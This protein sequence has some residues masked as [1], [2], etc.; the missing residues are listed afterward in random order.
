MINFGLVALCMRNRKLSLF[1]IITLYIWFYLLF[2]FSLLFKRLQLHHQ[3]PHILYINTK[4]LF[5]LQEELEK[6]DAFVLVYSVVDKASFTRVEQ[7]LQSLQ[8]MDLIR[9]RPVIIVANK[10]DLARSRS[11][12]SQ[13]KFDLESSINICADF[14]LFYVIC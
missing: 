12:S 13:G 8:D 9:T 5:C 1:Y 2:L 6:S 3:T 4:I 14:V 7:L 10:I 11:V